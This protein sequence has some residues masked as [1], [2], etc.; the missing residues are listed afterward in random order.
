[1]NMDDKVIEGLDCS[2]TQRPIKLMKGEDRLT[3]VT[4]YD[5]EEDKDRT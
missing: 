5:Y 3:V 2:R 4:Y 1:M